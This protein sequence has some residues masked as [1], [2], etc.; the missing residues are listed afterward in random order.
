MKIPQG[1]RFAAVP[2]Q[3]YEGKP[4]WHGK[5]RRIGWTRGYWVTVAND[6]GPIIY[7]SPEAARCGAIYWASENERPNT[8]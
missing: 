1:Y 5:V 2:T 4:A 3:P 7:A 8:N 6:Y